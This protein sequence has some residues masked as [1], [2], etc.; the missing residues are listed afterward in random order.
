[1]TQTDA[2]LLQAALNDAQPFRELYDRYAG[3]MHGY[4]SRRTDEREAAYDLTAETF[5]QA[6]AARARFRDEAGGSAG[7]WLFAIAGHVFAQSVRRR[8]SSGRRRSGSASSC[9]S[10]ASRRRPRRPIRGSTDSTRRSTSCPTGCRRR[11]RLRVIDD[12][13]TA[14]SRPGSGRRKERRAYASR[15]RSRDCAR[16]SPI[17]RWRQRDERAFDS[18]T[19]SRRLRAPISARAGGQRLRRRLAVAVAAP[20]S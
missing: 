18:A 16:E 3:R 1:M 13:D 11:L 20:R 10:I 4:F 15:V 8:G 9:G 17:D 14:R 19:R 2:E 12:L 7:P 5:A 6:W